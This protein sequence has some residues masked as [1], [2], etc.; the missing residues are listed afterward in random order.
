MGLCWSLEGGGLGGSLSMQVW[1]VLI[2]WVHACAEHRNSL[3]GGLT[4][5][6]HAFTL[7]DPSMRVTAVI[8]HTRPPPLN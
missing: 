1:L 5:N 3:H 6:L 2:N 4:T 8:R 7:G